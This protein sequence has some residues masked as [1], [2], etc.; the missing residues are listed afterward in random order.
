MKKYDIGFS[1][2]EFSKVTGTLIWYYCICKRET[3]LMAR[4]ISP[5]EDHEL[6]DIG[7][8]IHEHSYSRKEKEIQFGNMKLDIIENANGTIIVEEIK[9]TSKFIES[10]KMQLLF[11][12]YELEKNGITAEGLLL[13]PEER[14]RER[15]VLDK[16]K[17]SKLEAIIKDILRI[18]IMDKPPE[19][20]KINYCKSCAYAEFCW[21]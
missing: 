20:V 9:K 4:N 10:S 7:R 17:R 12:L 5:D 6:L 1:K 14:K 16:E 18:I 13:F 19:P 8:F 3:W 2:R 11:Y 21:A 15:V